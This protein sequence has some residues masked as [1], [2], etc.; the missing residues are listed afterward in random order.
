[1]VEIL[2]GILLPAML[3]SC[4]I[5]FIIYLRGYPLRCPKRFFKAIF[6]KSSGGMGA[7]MTALAGTLGVGNISGVAAA[8]TLGGAGAL[9]W[10]WVC[11]VFAMVVKYAEIVLA[12]QGRRDGGGGAMY[13]IN[14]RPLAVLFSVLCLACGFS[15]GNLTQV[16]A[17]GGAIA[18]LLP[19]GT[20]TVSLSFALI[21]P[22][23]LLKGKRGVFRFAEKAVPLMTAFYCILSLVF[24]L[25]NR[26]AL[27][28]AMKS[29]FKDA[30]STRAVGWGSAGSAW[31][32]GLRYG[33]SRGMISNEAGCGTAPIAHAA[34]ANAPAVQG[35]FGVVEV[36]VDTILLCTLTG[37]CVLISPAALKAGDGTALVMDTFASC[38]GRAA[39]FLLAPA[40]V[41]F[42]FATVVCWFY[43]C[44]ECLYFLINSRR[45]NKILA[46]FF[47]LLCLTAPLFTEERLFLVCDLLIFSLATLNI[48]A[49]FWHR[50]QIRRETHRYFIKTK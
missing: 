44:C 1:M 14:K 42:A 22:F 13:Y 36:F 10:M 19:N 3:L 37:L 11:A 23:V 28:M 8:V 30:F 9:F 17:A 46:V 18:H 40:M 49:L 33:A 25:R 4:G 47:S 27:P 32:L 31:I 6:R 50:K 29:V 35:C 5:F 21:L 12:L 43:Y 41:L 45:Y 24:L 16:R 38:F 20:L 34:S 7:L 15:M 39:E 2:L 48:P 26:S